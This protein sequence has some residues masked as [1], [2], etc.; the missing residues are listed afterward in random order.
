MNLGRTQLE[1]TDLKI[2]GEV[3]ELTYYYG[4]GKNS[5]ALNEKCKTCW[6]DDNVGSF[7]IIVEKTRSAL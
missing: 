4:I 2:K 1:K 7:L 6:Y 3:C 5:A